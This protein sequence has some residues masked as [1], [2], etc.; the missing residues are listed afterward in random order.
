MIW[1][2]SQLRKVTGLAGGKKEVPNSKRDLCGTRRKGSNIGR[3]RENEGNKRKGLN[4]RGG[5]EEWSK[6]A[7]LLNI[8]KGVLYKWFEVG[9]T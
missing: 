1:R 4:I 5:K 9:N 2:Q 6:G 3:L 7:S 8:I